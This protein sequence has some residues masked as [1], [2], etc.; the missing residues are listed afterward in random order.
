MRKVGRATRLAAAAGL[1]LV[2]GACSDESDAPGDD[3]TATPTTS[4]FTPTVT[5]TPPSDKELASQAATK[6]LRRYYAVRN[7]VRQDT[8]KPVRELRS[9]S[10]STDL[11]AQENF[12][13]IQRKDGLRQ[14]GDTRIVELT[15]QSVSLDNSDPKAGRVPTVVADVC[16]DV[17]GVDIVNANGRSV[18]QDDRPDRGWVR[19][20]VSNYQWNSDR[21]GAWRVATSE[22]LKQP[23][24]DAA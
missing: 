8:S 13:R 3:P 19:H 21:S 7:E 5:E 9:V 12:I 22:N 2:L 20:S 16:Y 1:L 24:C 23:P 14:V 4:S 18:V 15:V 11:T 17:T 6:L 10:I